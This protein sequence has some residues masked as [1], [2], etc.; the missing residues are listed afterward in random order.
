MAV[1]VVDHVYA[2]LSGAGAATSLTS[3][4]VTGTGTNRA[5][6]AL[7]GVA[8]G[9]DP[10]DITGCTWDVA[11]PEAMTELFDSGVISTF[12]IVKAYGLAGQESNTDTVTISFDDENLNAFYV[13]TTFDGVDQDTPFGTVQM[14][15]NF[16]PG[17]TTLTFAESNDDDRIADVVLAVSATSL[18]QGA[19]QTEYESPI[20]VVAGGYFYSASHQAGS[21]SGD[22]MTWSS[23][24][25]IT[26]IHLAVNV[27]AVPE[28]PGFLAKPYRFNLRV[29]LIRASTY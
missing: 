16:A 17:D 1:T 28:G 3:G 21:V 15:A 23:A 12:Y 19:D 25:E 6:L 11:S 29:P 18:S 13:I 2:N 20:N 4:T 14:D 8:H 5:I 26:S 10:F 7:G 24:D 9:P 22:E 27:N